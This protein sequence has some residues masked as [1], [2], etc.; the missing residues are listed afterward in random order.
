MNRN[1]INKKRKKKKGQLLVMQNSKCLTYIHSALMHGL[2]DMNA[3]LHSKRVFLI[4]WWWCIMYAD[5][6]LHTIAKNLGITI[7]YLTRCRSFAKDSFF[8][9]ISVYC[10]LY[11]PNLWPQW[12]LQKVK[13]NG[14]WI[15]MMILDSAVNKKLKKKNKMLIMNILQPGYSPLVD[16]YLRN[17]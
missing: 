8:L 12:L 2:I 5:I 16:F 15:K 17:F 7:L 9:S 4:W 13:I 1:C 14:T 11:G 3:S 10:F 6:L